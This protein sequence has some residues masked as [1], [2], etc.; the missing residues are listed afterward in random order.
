MVR[1]AYTLAHNYCKQFGINSS[2]IERCRKVVEEYLQ[3]VAGHDY[4]RLMWLVERATE[5]CAVSLR[6]AEEDRMFCEYYDRTEQA[7]SAKANAD[8]FAEDFQF[9]AALHVLITDRY[10]EE[11]AKGLGEF[12][13]S[14]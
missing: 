8:K 7:E 14:H 4:R 12:F 2:D 3:S 1:D 11:G 9:L 13:K 6:E 5:D 10:M